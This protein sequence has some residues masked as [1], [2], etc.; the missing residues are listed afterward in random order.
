M[1]RI[2][3]PKDKSIRTMLIKM[4]WRVGSAIT[5]AQGHAIIAKGTC[6]GCQQRWSKTHRKCV[7]GLFPSETGK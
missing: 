4:G 6:P 1:P 7:P 2:F 3:D 5:F